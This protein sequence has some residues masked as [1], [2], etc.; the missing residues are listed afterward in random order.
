VK[1]AVTD[2]E[3]KR[4]LQRIAAAIEASKSRLRAACLPVSA[5][6]QPLHVPEPKP[7]VQPQAQG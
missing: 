2:K 5:P 6:A 1:K 4:N 7:P 3:H